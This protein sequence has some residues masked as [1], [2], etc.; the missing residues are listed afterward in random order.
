MNIPDLRAEDTGVTLE[1][2]S[3][4]LEDLGDVLAQ[5]YR[6][7]EFHSI[8]AQIDPIRMKR[9]I[10]SIF[11]QDAFLHMFESDFGRGVILGAYIQQFIF[12]ENEE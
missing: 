11:D 12:G 2:C 8:T 7:D 10:L 6:S 3:V 5:A 9:E 4:L 1:H